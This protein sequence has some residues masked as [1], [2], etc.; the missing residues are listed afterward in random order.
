M[1]LVEA[2]VELHSQLFRE[3]EQQ[4][5]GLEVGILYI[6]AHPVVVERRQEL[7]AQERF[8]R[9]DLSGDLDEAFAV[10]HGNQE[11]V[12]RLLAARARIEKARIRGN[13]ERRLAQTEVGKVDHFA[14]IGWLRRRCPARNSAAGLE[15]AEYRPPSPCRS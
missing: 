10:R 2:P 15:F 7:A 5:L 4:R 9:A 14:A 3:T 6:R 12:E 13:P 11:R 8:A 1:V